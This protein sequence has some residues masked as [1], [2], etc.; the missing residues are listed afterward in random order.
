MG[1]FSRIIVPVDGS[2][3][4]GRAAAFAARLGSA[5]GIPITLAHVVPMTPESVM[6]LSQLDKAEVEKVQRRRADTVLSEVRAAMGEAGEGAEEKVMVGD[7]AEEILR[8]VN[9]EPEAL[10]VMGRRGLSPVRTLML[11]SV[12]EKVLRGTS[13]TVTLVR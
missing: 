13:S 12:S 1:E 8:Y 7:P 5:L 10:V 4:S 3:G 11:G 2:E 6:G 9:A